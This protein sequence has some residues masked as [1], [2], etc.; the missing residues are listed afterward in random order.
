L[1]HG[2][3][4]THAGFRRIRPL[5]ARHFALYLMDR[6]GRGVSGDTEAYELAR[7]YEDVA[8][9]VDAIPEPVNLFAHS[10]GAMCALEG[11]RLTQNLAR[12]V[13]YEPSMNRTTGDPKREFT[14]DEMQR[15]VATGD[16]DGVVAIHL[17]NIINT[18]EDVIEKQR[19]QAQSWAARMAMAHTMPRELHALRS[20]AFEPD[21]YGIID[22]PVRFLVGEK[23]IGRGPETA[24]R[25]IE[26]IPHADLV[27]LE[28][29]GHF[30][31]LSAPELVARQLVDFF[32]CG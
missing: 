16:R 5:L 21:R 6:R 19:E 9:V 11:A 28:G 25:L 27:L 26:A 15:L 18:P 24:R 7:E 10:F 3:G 32:G 31:Y 30:G 17:R 1:V 20:H 13:C 23:T 8:A 29:Q 14:I 4:D 22:V 2:T 12:I